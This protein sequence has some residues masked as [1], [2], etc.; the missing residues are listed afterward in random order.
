MDTIYNIKK[1]NYLLLH[2]EKVNWRIIKNYK[3]ALP[4]LIAYPNRVDWNYM[5]HNYSLFDTDDDWIIDL[6]EAH[7]YY[8]KN[9][10]PR[11]LTQRKLEFIRLYPEKIN[12]EIL[13]ES[14]HDIWAYDLFD[15]FPEY[16]NWSNIGKH[17]WAI[18][19]IYKY[20]T[21]SNLGKK[22]FMRNFFNI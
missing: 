19:L 16:T 12:W 18:P 2:P 3:W 5:I 11:N 20:P 1:I 15:E 13:G 14:I 22:N 6:F 9:W 17:P 4:L 7:P 10:I 21:F 8:I